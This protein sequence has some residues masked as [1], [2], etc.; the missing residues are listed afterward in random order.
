VKYSLDIPS[1]FYSPPP[2][3]HTI[4][5]T[6]I[7]MIFYSR[8]SRTRMRTESRQVKVWSVASPSLATVLWPYSPIS[9]LQSGPEKC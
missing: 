1:R 9:W 3:H 4:P 5:L 8:H 7:E 2:T 6:A